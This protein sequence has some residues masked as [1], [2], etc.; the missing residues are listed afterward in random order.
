M[1]LE[2]REEVINLYDVYQDLLTDKQKSYFEEY[3]FDDLSIGEIAEN[4]AVSRNAVFDQLKR[5]IGILK[6]YEAKLKLVDKVNQIENIDMPS[7]T[8]EK[9]LD[10]LKG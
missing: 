9:I 10:I 4:H 2:K 1:T 5:V 6:D 8:K 3:Y 7:S